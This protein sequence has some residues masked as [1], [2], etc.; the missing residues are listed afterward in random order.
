MYVLPPCASQSPAAGDGN[1]LGNFCKVQDERNTQAL[2]KLARGSANYFAVFIVDA[3][4][5]IFGNVT[6]DSSNFLDFRDLCAEEGALLLGN[7][8]F[9]SIKGPGDFLYLDCR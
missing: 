5:Q 4:Y 9:L 1:L 3:G 6:R 7:S 8:I 2:R